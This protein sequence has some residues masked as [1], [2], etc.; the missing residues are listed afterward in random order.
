MVR[1]LDSHP[2]AVPWVLGKAVLCS[3]MPSIIEWSENGSCCGNFADFVG[4]KKRGG[5]GSIWYV[6]NSINLRELLDSVCLSWIWHTR[7]ILFKSH[8][9]SKFALG[10]NSW[11]PWN[12]IHSQPCR[13]PCKLFIHNVIFG[14]SGLHLRVWS[15]LRRSPPFR[16]M[17]AFRFEWSRA[18]SLCVWSGPNLHP[19][20]YNHLWKPCEEM[21]I[22]AWWS[23]TLK[24]LKSSISSAG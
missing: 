24:S 13:T 7:K 16:P 6:S 10:K 2:K 12:F 11:R 4:E 9:H 17:R 22:P 18:F 8:G 21:N 14:R 3:H 5:I 1:T 19:V 15:E 20:V 23:S